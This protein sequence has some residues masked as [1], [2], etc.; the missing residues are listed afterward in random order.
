MVNLFEV[1]VQFEQQLRF[2]FEEGAVSYSLTDMST[3]V[4]IDFFSF[5]FLSLFLRLLENSFS[6]VLLAVVVSFLYVF[7]LLFR[8]RFLS[9]LCILP[10]PQHPLF[11]NSYLYCYS[12]TR[13]VFFPPSPSFLLQTIRSCRTSSGRWI[14]AF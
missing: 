13:T 4:Y 5:L 6:F 1:L 12:L 10:F 2:M 8:L 7:G 11:F 14:S 9:F 3:Y